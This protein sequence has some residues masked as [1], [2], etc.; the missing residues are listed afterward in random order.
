VS[1]YLIDRTRFT[2]KRR[3]RSWIWRRRRRGRIGGREEEGRGGKLKSPIKM[4][5][6][7]SSIKRVDNFGA[8]YFL[9]P[10]R[11]DHAYPHTSWPIY[12]SLFPYRSPFLELILTDKTKNKKKREKQ[13]K[14]LE[15]YECHVKLSRKKWSQIL[16]TSSIELHHMND[17]RQALAKEE[18]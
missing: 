4:S 8:D 7:V 5:L 14:H 17:N 3:T 16:R 15:Y 9:R 12:S 13:N 11:G 1:W 2:T 18:R 6:Y 10:V